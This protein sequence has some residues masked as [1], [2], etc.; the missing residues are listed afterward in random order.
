[1]SKDLRKVRSE[2]LEE[3]EERCVLPWWAL[4]PKGRPPCPPDK[5]AAAGRVKRGE[6]R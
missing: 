6:S 3:E 1:M 2:E 5:S 4:C